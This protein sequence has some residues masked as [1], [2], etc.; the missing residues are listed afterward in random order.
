MQLHVYDLKACKGDMERLGMISQ[1]VDDS[2]PG[3]RK[4]ILY[5]HRPMVPLC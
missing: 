3:Y 1:S 2:E 4:V 5:A